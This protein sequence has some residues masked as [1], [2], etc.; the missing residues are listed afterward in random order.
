MATITFPAENVKLVT[1]ALERYGIKNKFL[2]A[3]ILGT[4][5]KE[6]GFVLHPETSYKNTSAKRIRMVF[7]KRVEKFSDSELT[8]LAQVDSNFFEQVYGIPSGKI[9]IRLGNT[10][11]GDGYKYR[12]RGFNGLTGRANYSLYGKLT[13]L[14]LVNKPDLL[15]N[16]E[17][18]SEVLAMFYADQITAGEK[19]GK[20][21]TSTGISKVSEINSLQEGVKVAVLIT[22]GLP[23]N[24]LETPIL[25]EGMEKATEFAK[26][27]YKGVGGGFGVIN[28]V[29]LAGLVTYFLVKQKNSPSL[30]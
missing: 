4:I 3:G 12:G 18:A 24:Y 22:A 29:L 23:E 7:G 30:Q 15:N 17:N 5:G 20:L 10:Q 26:S 27:L 25:V 1:Q 8:A 16:K 9:G 21:K 2:L 6:T 13:G 14:D 11:T 19:S 28:I